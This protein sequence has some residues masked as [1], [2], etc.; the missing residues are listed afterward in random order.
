MS[1]KN[2][3]SRM[4]RGPVCESLEGRR[5]LSAD[6][7]ALLHNGALRIRGTE[8]ADDIRVSVNAIDTTKLDVSLNGTVLGTFDSAA[9]R[10]GIRVDGLGGDDSLQIIETSTPISLRAT[11]NG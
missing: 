2:N 4:T 5:L 1:S 6:G 3:Q 8:G 7:T 10:R 11:I 9:A